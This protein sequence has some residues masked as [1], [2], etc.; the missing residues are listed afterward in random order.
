MS[1][2]IG[3][4]RNVPAACAGPARRACAEPGK[5][6]SHCSWEG[7]VASAGSWKARETLLPAGRSGAGGRGG[8][9]LRGSAF[10]SVPVSE[11]HAAFRLRPQPR[12]CR[13]AYSFPH[14]R[15]CVPSCPRPRY[16]VP[17]PLPQ[18]SALPLGS[19]FSPAFSRPPRARPRS[20]W[21]QGGL[22]RLLPVPGG[23]GLHF[24]AV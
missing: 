14:L 10:F 12:L 15:L 1:P 23:A 2:L 7:G 5:A 21:G 3:W 24:P 9:P 20:L 17:D 6:R 11:F 4:S 19:S 13:W 22:A 16:V 8:A 18:F